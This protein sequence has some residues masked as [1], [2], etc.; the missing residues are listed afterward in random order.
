VFAMLVSTDPISS[1]EHSAVSYGGRNVNLGSKMSNVDRPL[2]VIQSGRP[3]TSDAIAASI[4]G[5][6]PWIWSFRCAR[7]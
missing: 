5:A 3:A 7:G 2:R 1:P 4:S 6:T